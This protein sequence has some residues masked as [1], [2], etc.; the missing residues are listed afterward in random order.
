MILNLLR[1]VHES[2]LYLTQSLP[3]TPFLRPAP[4]CNVGRWK[5]DGTCAQVSTVPPFTETGTSENGIA[6]LISGP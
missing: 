1:I 4:V 6:G 5:V 2:H 3:P